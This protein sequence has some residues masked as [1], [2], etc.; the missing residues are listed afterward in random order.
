MAGGQIPEPR[1]RRGL[2]TCV[3][4]LQAEVMSAATFTEASSGV[5]SSL[6]GLVGLL[7]LLYACFVRGLGFSYQLQSGLPAP[8]WSSPKPRLAFRSLSESQGC[9]SL[10]RYGIHRA[11]TGA[12][13]LWPQVSCVSIF[14]LGKSGNALLGQTLPHWR[15]KARHRMWHMNL[16]IQT[17]WHILASPSSSE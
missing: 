5:L 3:L 16:H 9:G 17:A 1:P 15:V 10:D 13:F 14:L 2:Y 7:C 11:P 6:V 12:P 8:R 4:S